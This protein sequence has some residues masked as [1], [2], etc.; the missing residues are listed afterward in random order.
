MT[1]LRKWM[2]LGVAGVAVAGMMAMTSESDACFLFHRHQDHG[3]VG[4]SVGCVGGSVGSVGG[5][6][7][8]VGGHV[9]VRTRVRGRVRG[10]SIGG[11]IG[12][13]FGGSVGGCY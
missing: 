6:V 12:G 11:S 13:S 5:S 10:G 1:R 7:G 3:S 4:G 8:S 2:I 9:R